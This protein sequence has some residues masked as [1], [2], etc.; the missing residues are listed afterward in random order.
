LMTPVIVAWAA[1]REA[2]TRKMAARTHDRC[3]D[4]LVTRDS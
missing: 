4:P 2:V 1:R 3:T